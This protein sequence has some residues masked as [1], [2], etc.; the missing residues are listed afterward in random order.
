MGLN[1]IQRLSWLR[2]H[3]LVSLIKSRVLLIALILVRVEFSSEHLVQLLEL[4]WHLDLGSDIMLFLLVFGE[5]LVAGGIVLIYNSHLLMWQFMS[6][7]QRMTR[8]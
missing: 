8:V 7:G 2:V 5:I 6:I 4:Q 3:P 1:K